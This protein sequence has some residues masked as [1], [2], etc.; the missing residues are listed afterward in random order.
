[1]LDSE[2]RIKVRKH[3]LIRLTKAHAILAR[4]P[5]QLERYTPVLDALIDRLE[6]AWNQEDDAALCCILQEAV[7]M[8]NRVQNDENGQTDEVLE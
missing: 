2:K 4:H 7:E 5:Q 6:D 3:I 8:L 1:M